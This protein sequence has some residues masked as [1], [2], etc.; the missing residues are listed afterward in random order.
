VKTKSDYKADALAKFQAGPM[1]SRALRAEHKAE[2]DFTKI[3]ADIESPIEAMFLSAFFEEYALDD[4]VLWERRAHKYFGS[5]MMRTELAAQFQIENYRC[6]FVIW[7]NHPNGTITKIV[8]EC[9]GHDFHERTKEQAQRD[10]SRDRALTA[11]AWRV[12]RFTGAELYRDSE[13]CVAEV[14][15]IIE[16]DGQYDWMI[17]NG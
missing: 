9:D 7:H 11:R 3:L 16:S 2:D 5:V 14:V 17:A 13:A 15:A 6:D 8:V 12:L 4:A 10:R 1:K